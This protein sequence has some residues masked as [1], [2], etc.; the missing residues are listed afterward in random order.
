MK[1]RARHDKIMLSLISCSAIALFASTLL[2]ADEPIRL[3][4]GLVSGKRVG[5][6]VKIRAYLGIPFAAPPL[7]KLRWQPP[8]PPESWQGVRECNSFGTTCPQA[9]YPAG[10]VYALAPQ[11]QSE[12]CLFLNVWTGADAPGDKRPVMVWIHG[13]ALTRGSSSL[14]VYDGAA[15]ARKGVVLVTINYRLGPFGYF[16]HPALSKESPQGSSGNYGVLDQIAALEWVKR[17]IA[18]FGGDPDRVT[19]FGESAGS[20]SVCSLV[21]TPLAKGLFHRAIGQ[22]GGCF[23]PMHY[24]KTQRGPMPAAEKTGEGL[25]TALGC[26]DAADPLAAL[27]AKSTEEILAVATKQPAAARTRPNVDNWVFPD[28]IYNI[29]AKGQQNQVP[30]LLGSNADEATSLAVPGLIPTKAESFVEAAKRKY[31]DLSERY[32]STYPVTS[33]SDV[34]DAYLHTVR[35]EWFTWEMRTWARLTQKSG[36]KAY[37]YFFSRVPPRPDSK[38]YGAYHAAEIIYVFNNLDKATWQS[39]PPDRALA[40]A[41]SSYWV[42]FAAAGDPNGNGQTAWPAYDPEKQSCLEFGDKIGQRNGVLRAQCEFFDDYY[43]AKR[44]EAAN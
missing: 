23:S 14:P 36:S 42:R 30:V 41:M 33:D 29:Y 25:A 4:S 12:D 34:R 31:A 43:A 26:G 37:L 32:L 15:L 24:L 3:D 17:N 28:D 16:A 7:G 22:S 2:A 6:D 39:E 11:P 10:S 1:L 20:W 38:T 44:A 19:I 21:A 8:R 35:D 9:P 13:G 40:D 18:A 27:R 5:D